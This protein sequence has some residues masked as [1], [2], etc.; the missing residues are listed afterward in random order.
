MTGEDRLPSDALG[1]AGLAAL[2]VVIATA[3]GDT[4]LGI[5]VT[6]VDYLLLVYAMFRVPLRTS[7]MTLMFFV[8]VLPNP[9]DCTPGTWR[10]PFF[11]AGAI[12]IAHL[13]AVD[14]SIGWLSSASFSGM[15]L[16]LVALFMIHLFRNSTGSRIDRT[17]HVPGPDV[18]TKLAKISLVA[19]AFVWINGMLRGGDF[20]MSLWQ[21]N[22][23]MYLPC[24][25]LL[26][27][28]A[29]RGPKDH[30][31]LAKVVLAAATYKALLAVYV[32]RV[33]KTFVDAPGGEPIALPH[34]TSHQDSILFAVAFVLVVA[35]FLERAVTRRKW[36]LALLP[37]IIG[38]GMQANNRRLAWVQVALV[39]LMVYLVSADSP[40]KRKIRRG[41]MIAAPVI[42]LYVFAGWNSGGGS[43]FKPV[44]ILRSVAD[45][46]SDGS[47][48]WR[49]LEN[50]DLIATI[51]L[52]P[53][54]GTGYG[55]GYE[56]VIVLPRVDYDLERFVPHNSI[57]G[58]WAYC[59]YLGYAALTMLWSGGVYFALRAYRS[60]KA[61]S[62]RAAALV[63]F[64]A[65]LIYMVQSW[66][67][68]GLGAPIGV[69]TIAT[70]IAV[71]G[72][73]A[74]ATGQWT[75]K[76]GKSLPAR[77]QQPPRNVHASSAPAGRT[78]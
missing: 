54:F 65:V 41:V 64:G 72:K 38:L 26:F 33:I 22:N 48:Y 69:F 31:A 30:P 21:L 16:I 2:L 39:L 9:A 17:G 43:L 11:I 28:V 36:L 77:G 7:L 61:G 60:S 76:D 44:R 12:L 45:A 52:N 8:M 66:G 27:N 20:N 42:A 18:L 73:L 59:G 70:A 63:S 19:I 23:V 75:T 74:V 6:F 71:A 51:K 47:S 3:V 5:L 29:L 34:A 14:R 25:F 10:A 24:L 55:H 49:E 56:E 13:N 50:Y 4:T 62:L 37:V 53:I 32:M 1:A 67:D 40:I 78:T 46:K 15:D 57:L 35:L 68:L 58:L